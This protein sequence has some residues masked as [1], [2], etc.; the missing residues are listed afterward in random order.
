MGSFD[1]VGSR[2]RRLADQAGT[3]AAQ[4]ATSRGLTGGAAASY[5]STIENDILAQVSEQ[6]QARRQAALGNFAQLATSVLLA[7]NTGGASLLGGI[8]AAKNLIAAK[9]QPEPGQ[10]GFQLSPATA[11][12]GR[13]LSFGLGGERNA[14]GQPTFGFGQPQST[15]GTIMPRPNAGV[16]SPATQSTTGA[17]QQAQP[18]TQLA[19][20][21]QQA[22]GQQRLAAQPLTPLMRSMLDAGVPQASAQD[23]GFLMSP[24][25]TQ[26]TQNSMAQMKLP[27]LIRTALGLAEGAFV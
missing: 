24:Q 27:D 1:S 6:N 8:G 18:M 16:G 13:A 11:D 7:P 2:G 19:Q 3:R 5:Q 25:G 17:L 14:Q 4:A 26:L 22:V 21:V 12:Q 20:A 15:Q 9:N 10:A 23:P